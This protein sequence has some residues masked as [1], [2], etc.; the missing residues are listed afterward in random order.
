MKEFVYTITDPEGIHAR[1]AGVLVKEAAKYPCNVTIAKD[2]REVDA[3]RIMGVMS[4]GVK[5]GQEITMKTDGDEEE[6]AADALL[7]FLK[8]NL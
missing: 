1:P 7:A 2:G 6:A 8:E 5:C 3:K 4:L